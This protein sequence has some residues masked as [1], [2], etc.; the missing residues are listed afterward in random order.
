MAVGMTE[1]AVE[2]RGQSVG[3]FFGR[4]AFRSR[5]RGVRPDSMGNPRG[6]GQRSEGLVGATSWTAKNPTYH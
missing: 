5:D 1:K 6:E 4:R 3:A 2:Q